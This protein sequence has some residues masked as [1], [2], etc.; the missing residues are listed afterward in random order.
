MIEGALMELTLENYV[1]WRMLNGSLCALCPLNKQRRV[2]AAGP[3]DADM[4]LIGEAPGADEEAHR[5]GVQPYGEPFVGRAGWALKEHVLTPAGPEFAVKQG[6][7]HRLTAF[8]M[9]TI[10]CR[11]PKNKLKS[12]IGAKAVA[13]CSRSAVA[14]LNVLMARKRRTFVP[15]GDAALKITKGVSGIGKHRGRV[16]ARG[17]E[18]D[19]PLTETERLKILLRGIKP[20]PEWKE[21]EKALR[22]I[23]TWQRLGLRKK[24]ATCKVCGG[25]KRP[26]IGK[27]MCA[28]HKKPKKQKET[29]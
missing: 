25:T 20:P 28:G 29:S 24:Y 13:A 23:M 21:H 8:V 11:P 27:L 15:L 19:M 2:G 6:Q 3:I 17:D 9:N 7:G 4:V 12:P 14:V 18:F 5:R 26:L 16:T 22:K 10:M 1:Q